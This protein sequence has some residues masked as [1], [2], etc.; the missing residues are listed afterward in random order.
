[1]DVSGEILMRGYN[2][3]LEYYKK[4]KETAENYTVDGWFKTGDSGVRLDAGAVIEF[5]RGKVVSFKIPKHV[6]FVSAFPMTASGKIRKV[7]L[8]EQ[9][10]CELLNI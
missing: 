1:M 2:L 6:I 8:R 9:V 10:K 7:E 5:C 4:P 3:M